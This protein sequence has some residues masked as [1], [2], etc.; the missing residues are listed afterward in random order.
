MNYQPTSLTWSTLQGYEL[1]LQPQTGRSLEPKQ[2]RGVTQSIKVWHFGDKTK[3]VEAIKLRW[4]V[5]Y[6]VA[7]DLRNEVGE[8]PE[9]SIA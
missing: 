2:S 3:K 4:R 5:A 1:Q 9:F 6:K 7:G 8:I